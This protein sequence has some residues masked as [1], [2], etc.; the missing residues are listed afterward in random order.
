M[1]M[2]GSLPL[3][4]ILY[5][6]VYVL[7][8]LVCLGAIAR[9]LWSPL[10]VFRGPTCGGCGHGVRDMLQGV[11]PECGGQYAKVGIA[12]P[13]MAVRL[14]GSL[15]IALL[16]WTTLMVTAAS[17]THGWL[18]QRAWAWYSA[19][20]SFSA[21]A[22]GPQQ[23]S[24]STVMRTFS[25]NGRI[26]ESERGDDQT[27]RISV[28]LTFVSD[29]DKVQSG[30]CVFKLR[31]NGEPES[32]PLSI[33]LS[34]G[35]FTIKD[36]Q[37]KE[38]AKGGKDAKVD[39]AAVEKW[40]K[41]AGLDTAGAAVKRSMKDMVRIARFAKADPSGLNNELNG[42]FRNGNEEKGT[43]QSNGSSSSSGGVPVGGAMATLALAGPPGV[44]TAELATSIGVLGTL[45]L[46][47][48]G[49]IVWRNRR[50][51]KR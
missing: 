18:E 8:G 31:R 46:V 22:S 30:T 42:S 26:A 10:E 51:V 36:D 27:Y 17:F 2:Q 45:Y 20:A 11:C 33:D 34:D 35:S 6:A 4:M 15:P 3:Q 29:A 24:Y 38:I 19:A 28:A 41:G 39:E 13:S 21:G 5:Y 43:L 9:A 44:G 1:M 40:F 50:M 12:T 37:G 47:G 25:P 23:E 14:R 49:G 48:C 7:L 16:A 32:F